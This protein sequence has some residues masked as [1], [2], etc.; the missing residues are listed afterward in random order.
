MGDELLRAVGGAL[1]VV[2]ARHGLAARYGGEEFALVVDGDL[3]AARQ[4]AERACAA[5]RAISVDAVRVTA[6][7]GAATGTVKDALFADADA[8]LYAAKRA[9]KDRVATAPVAP[10][11]LAA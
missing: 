9:G 5:I 11:S 10:V 2:S 8:A 4:L 7:C 1:G 6:S 3:D